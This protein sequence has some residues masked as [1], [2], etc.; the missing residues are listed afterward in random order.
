MGKE[1][2][3]KLL[4][5]ALESMKKDGVQAF[6]VGK[7]RVYF[8][9]G[10]LEFLE[11]ERMKGWDKWAVD[12]QRVTRGWLVRRQNSGRKMKRKAPYATT[13]QC[14]WR[15]YVARKEFKKRRKHKKN[16]KKMDKKRNK[17]VVKIQ[18]YVRTFLWRPKFKQLLKE[19]REKDAL[20]TKIKDLEQAVREAEKS[21][22]KEVEEA[23]ARAEEE[24]E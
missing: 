7:T 3:T 21:R 9:A 15:C 22:A 2:V 1:A 18:A 10:A 4:S 17:A 11:H 5:A 23:R 8:R 6:V 16:K 12:I 14:A 24:M 19:K 20:R 13:L